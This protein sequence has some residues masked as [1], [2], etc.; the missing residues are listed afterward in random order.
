MLD[1][2]GTP[3]RGALV[4]IW[5]AGN[6]GAYIHPTSPITNRDRNLHGY[7]KFLAASDGRYLFRTVKPEIYPGRTRYIHF[8]LTIARQAGFATQLFVAGEALNANDMVSSV[9]RDA[10]QRA[11]VILTWIKMAS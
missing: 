8:Q 7:G 10:A 4:G 5:E 11:S 9:V 2:S 1:R 3:I 6:N